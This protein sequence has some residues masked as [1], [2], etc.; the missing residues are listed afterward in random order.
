MTISIHSFITQFVD[1]QQVFSVVRVCVFG[2]GQFDTIK[3]FNLISLAIDWLILNVW[4]FLVCTQSIGFNGFTLIKCLYFVSFTTASLDIKLTSAAQ[5]SLS[6]FLSLP[7]RTCVVPSILLWSPWNDRTTNRL[8]A[9]TFRDQCSHFKCNNWN[10]ILFGLFLSKILHPILSSSNRSFRQHPST[11]L[12]SLFIFFW[13]DIGEFVSVCVCVSVDHDQTK[14]IRKPFDWLV[15][16]IKINIIMIKITW[17]FWKHV[18]KLISIILKSI[19]RK[20]N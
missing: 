4:L 20:L 6:P 17:S 10:R 8:W 13:I 7:V 3:D 11:V 14:L 18:L 9:H 12:S 16:I 19:N 15:W 2:Q 1:K 5:V